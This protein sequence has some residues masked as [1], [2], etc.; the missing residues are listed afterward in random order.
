MAVM[1]WLSDIGALWPRQRPRRKRIQ[2]RARALTSRCTLAR[3]KASQRARRLVGFHGE[4]GVGGQE[5]RA[6][7]PVEPCNDTIAR[8]TRTPQS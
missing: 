4:G 1:D 8:S 7:F 5:A 3:S 2:R 6:L